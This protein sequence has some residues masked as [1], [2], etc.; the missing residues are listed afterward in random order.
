MQIYLHVSKNNRTFAQ[1]YFHLYSKSLIIMRKIYS[2]F[3]A[4]LFAGSMMA[5]ETPK[6]TLDFTSGGVAG[7]NTWKLPTA[8]TAVKTAQSY[9]SGGYT[10]SFSAADPGHKAQYNAIKQNSE[11]TGDTIWNGFLFGKKDATLTRPPM[12]FN[13]SKI[14]VYYI[15]AQGSPS[16]VHNI[17]VGDDA[18]STAVTGCQVSETAGD[19][20]VFV[21]ASN[22]QEAGTTYILKVTSKHNM[23]VSKIEFYEA[24]AGAPAN[25]TFSIAAGVYD[26]AQTVALSCPTA[27][28]DIYY[29]LDETE[30]T[31]A[32][33]KYTSALNIS[34]TTVIKAVAI[35]NAL[36]S[37]VVTA[38]YKIIT[39]EGDGSKDNPY[40]VADITALENSRPD[41]AW[42]KG[43]IV[44]T[45]KEGG[46]VED[47]IAGTNFTL[48]DATNQTTGCVAIE[49]PKGDIR[50]A[51]S[52]K[53]YPEYV[54]KLIKVY[55]APQV[56]FSA[57][58]VKGTSKYEFIDSPVTAISNTE[59]V[60]TKT[61][62]VIEN[63]QLF[64]I[65]NGV[66]YN[67]QG[68]I[69]K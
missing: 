38:R 29:T 19:S 62:K 30:P 48:G 21:I 56:Y 13:V 42:V 34:S 54:G 26:A 27:G 36:S 45:A 68:T 66:K 2:I 52:L 23:Q 32:S 64:I 50:N 3:A 24:V 57:P 12:S 46:L 11:P 6:V 17:F 63:G 18:V 44:G 22:K 53:A 16:T 5:A 33:T 7:Q 43:Y 69:V 28:A 47:T 1:N 59:A 15:S 31:S 60:E 14:V 49:L 8:S 4:V 61:L 65:K 25:P 41:S 58:G 10:V 40:T 37:S 35:K 39:L 55:G 9:T 67:A 51:L 20:S